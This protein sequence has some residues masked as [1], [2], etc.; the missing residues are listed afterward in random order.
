[1][2]P[3]ESTLRQLTPLHFAAAVNWP[4]GIEVLIA[5]GAD[6]YA[7]D[8]GG[9]YP[10]DYA[11]ELGSLRSVKLLLRGDCLP[12][13]EDFK[14]DPA[15]TMGLNITLAVRFISDGIAKAIISSLGAQ[16]QLLRDKRPYHDL[17]RWSMTEHFPTKN[18][19]ERAQYLFL[20][21]F[22]DIDQTGV[23]GLTPLMTACHF[24]EFDWIAYLLENGANP[25]K[26]H[27]YSNLTAGH[28]LLGNRKTGHPWSP[29]DFEKCGNMIQIAFDKSDMI[30]STCRCSPGGFTPLSVLFQGNKQSWERRD[31]FR[32]ILPYVSWSSQMLEEQVRAFIVG[33][34]FNRLQMTHTCICLHFPRKQFPH[35]DR[36]EIEDEEEEM[37]DHLE[38]VIA[39]W[40][41]LRPGFDGGPLEFLDGFLEELERE[42]PPLDNA[43][44]VFDFKDQKD[45]LSPG[46]LYARERI[47]FRRKRVLY[48]HN[49]CLSEENILALLF[50]NE[51]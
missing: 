9:L 51:R 7:R 32:A 47:D 43:M 48:G 4:E 17:I 40:D 26:Q 16:K 28:F 42:L 3:V 39:N 24:P 29:S 22:H 1:M 23:K 2:K 36:L 8:S 45:L 13:F 5:G 21:G 15:L 14:Y 30:E 41:S 25:S 27:G 37:N 31:I 34:V 18:I 46:R 50:G 49:E 20:A 12:Y 19:L 44:G 11:F 6:E 10:I 38:E 33:E 35:E